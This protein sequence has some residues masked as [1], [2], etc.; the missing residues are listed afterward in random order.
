M[1]KIII[2]DN[3]ILTLEKLNLYFSKYNTLSLDE[4]MNIQNK[5]FDFTLKKYGIDRKELNGGGE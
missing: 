4:F 2:N 5:C 3:A 1:N